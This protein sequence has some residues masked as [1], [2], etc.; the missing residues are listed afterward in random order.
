MIRIAAKI[1]PMQQQE[2][3]K[4]WILHFPHAIRI[5]LCYRILNSDGEKTIDIITDFGAQAQ[6]L[7]IL[8][9]DDVMH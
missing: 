8:I 1:A 6:R 5:S 2:K 9:N 4:E 7:P 3:N